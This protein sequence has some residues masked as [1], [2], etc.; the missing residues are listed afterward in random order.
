MKAG[1]PATSFWSSDSWWEPQGWQEPTILL[2]G[3]YKKDTTPVLSWLQNA[4]PELTARC[5]AESGGYT[6]YETKRVLQS[7]WIPL[8]TDLENNPQ[9]EARAAVGR[10]LGLLRLDHRP[11]VGLRTDSLPDINW[12]EIPKGEFI[13]QDGIRLDLATYFISRYPITCIHYQAFVDAEDGFFQEKWWEGLNDDRER[14]KFLLNDSHFST[15]IISK[16]P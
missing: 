15:M 8:L 5:V 9:P 4:N 6:P 1:K 7:C 13:Y 14:L 2:T 10:A 11:G 3:L 12:I 16:L